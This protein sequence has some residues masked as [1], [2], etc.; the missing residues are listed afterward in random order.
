MTTLIKIDE[1]IEA[2]SHDPILP[3]NFACSGCG[4]TV[5][6]RAAISALENPIVVIPACCA[7]VVEGLHPNIAYGVPVVNIAFAAHAATATGI[8]RA[9]KM[10]GEEHN[11]VVWS[12]DGGSFDIGLATLS[13]AAE[14]GEN[15]LHFVYDNSFYGNT[16]GQ[17][18]SS[19]P[20]GAYTTTSPAGKEK[21]RKS[22]ARIVAMHDVEYTATASIGYIRDLYTKV[23]KASK[24]KGFRFILIDAACP[25]G[26]NSDPAYSIELGKLAVKTG[27]F[28]LWEYEN[29]KLTFSRPTERVKD[30]S[31][32]TNIK[33]YLKYQGRFKD[34]LENEESL[35]LLRKDIQDELD[36]LQRLE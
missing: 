28:P 4:M 34:M 14:R 5:A 31:K 25:V 30:L 13:G 21:K 24:L 6:F 18:S 27:Y 23:K 7:S 17:R 20:R 19:T 32:R 12:G 15:I 8:A 22:L 33:E 35:N 16:G 36:M 2:E 11:V 1:I 9:K 26:W 10:R 3:G 29:N